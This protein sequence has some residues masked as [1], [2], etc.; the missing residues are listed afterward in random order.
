MGTR[1]KHGY[2]HKHR[3][4]RNHTQAQTK[5]QAQPQ[6]QPQPQTQALTQAQKQANAQKQGTGTDN[7]LHTKWSIEVR[8]EA[9]GVLSSE[10]GCLRWA[11]AYSAQRPGT[12]LVSLLARG[13]VRSEAPGLL[14]SEAGCMRFF[15]GTQ[16]RYK[17]LLNRLVNSKETTGVVDEFLCGPRL[18][19]S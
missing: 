2:G 4:S 14:S 18:T 13:D 10:A 6:A 3:H 17:A 8:S 1:D 9:P 16:T 15:G 12:Q 5:P 7:G 19:Y 11:V